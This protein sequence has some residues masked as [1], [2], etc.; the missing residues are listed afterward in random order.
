MHAPI[1]NN[2]KIIKSIKWVVIVNWIN[3][4]LGFISIV[5]L[6]RL[7]TPEAFGI[8]AII[9][10]AIQLTETFT[11]VGAE[12]YYIQKEHSTREDLN[13]AWTTNLITKTGATIVLAV[14]G[15]F[16]AYYYDYASLIPALLLASCLPL[17]N[18]LVNGEIIQ[19]KKDLEYKAFSMV[20]LYSKLVSSLVT[21]TLAFIF[22]SYWALLI[23]AI[24]ASV[25]NCLLSYMM[26]SD[27]TQFGLLNWRAQFHFSK[28]VMFKAVV[29]HLK[30]KFDTWFAVNISGLAGLGGYHLAKD[31]VLFPSRELI[32]PITGVLFTSIAKAQNY[33]EDQRS[34]ISKSIAIIALI[35]FPISFGWA[36]IAAPLVE[37]V[38]GEQW[39]P[40]TAVIASLGGLVVI[41]ALGDFFADLMVAVGKV[42]QLFYFDTV[43]L[44]MAFST[45][46]LFSSSINSLIEMAQIRVF[47]ALLVTFT[48]LWWISYLGII[49]IK[50]IFKCIFCPL[51]V[52]VIMNQVTLFVIEDLA[53]G[54]FA[55]F[56]TTAI[57]AIIVY[58]SL[59]LLVLKFDLLGKQES[60]FFK[61]ILNEGL[62]QITSKLH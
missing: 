31:L 36:L 24:F 35:G 19:Y 34:Q 28:W 4:L 43:T 48:G 59:I 7:L 2:N 44:L 26:I 25:A 45:L 38:L 37:L 42:K 5:I 41:F 18:A 15:P 9:M 21:I 40:Y 29:G 46:F 11:N 16:V 57:T 8:A 62:R 14:L 47:I 23:G 58:F 20:F 53:F 54:A 13:C 6:A 33:S 32:S 50:R 30:S 1:N 27:R 3:R 55:I 10:L 61:K 56:F 51:I 39:I 12:Q 49:S 22:H 52:A 17:I 60:T